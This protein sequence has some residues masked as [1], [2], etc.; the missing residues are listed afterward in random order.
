MA[1]AC[2]ACTTLHP[3]PTPSLGVSSCGS[4]GKNCW[5]WC[6]SAG[7]TASNTETTQTSLEAL[8]A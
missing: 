4:P 1:K 8:G 7:L 2:Q 6:P 5:P 3:V